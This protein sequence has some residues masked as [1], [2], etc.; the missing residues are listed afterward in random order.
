MIKF[1]LYYHHILLVKYTVKFTYE[2]DVSVPINV[3]TS[4]RLEH[5]ARRTGRRTRWVRYFGAPHALLDLMRQPA[6]G[7]MGSSAVLA[8]RF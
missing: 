6:V 1:N 3:N 5:N 4:R 7:T 8:P 2:Y